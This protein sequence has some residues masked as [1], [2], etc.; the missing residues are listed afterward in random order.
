MPEVSA[1]DDP[2]L[3]LISWMDREEQLFKRLERRIVAARIGSGFGGAD[4]ADVEGFLAF[5]LSVQN[6]RKARAGQAL[7]NHLEAVFTAQQIRYVRGAETENRNKPD[8]LFPGQNEYR[9]PLYPEARL[10]MLG[11]K[12]TLKDRWRQV[13]SEALRIPEKHLLTL[14]PGISENQTDEMQAKKLQLVVPKR[15]HNTY[16]LTQQA[17][18]IDVA[19]FI[20]VVRSRQET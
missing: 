10:T 14:E 5:S 2:D 7:E 19:D 6:R 15:L 12:S 4:E 13:L 1:A 20:S 11:A 16:R 8:F 18:L 9:D 17:W 3:A